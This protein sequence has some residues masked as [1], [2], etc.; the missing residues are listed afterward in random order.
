MTWTCFLTQNNLASLK[1]FV[2]PSYYINE[3]LD[4]KGFFSRMSRLDLYN[5][6]YVM[7]KYRG[8][9][10][11]DWDTLRFFSFNNFLH[12]DSAKNDLDPFYRKQMITT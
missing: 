3:Q 2:P 9:N 10:A 6:V 8:V 7:M 12:E 5:S 11:W 4:F 1:R